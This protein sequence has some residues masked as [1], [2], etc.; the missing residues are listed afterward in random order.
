MFGNATALV[1]PGMLTYPAWQVFKG[2]IGHL[3]PCMVRRRTLHTV[4]VRGPTIVLVM[5]RVRQNGESS[6]IN[7][8]ISN[9]ASQLFVSPVGHPDVW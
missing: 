9:P 7:S 5:A 6:S 1:R 8:I 4:C 3:L 2:A